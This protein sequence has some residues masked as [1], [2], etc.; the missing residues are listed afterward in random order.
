MLRDAWGMN[1]QPAAFGVGLEGFYGSEVFDD[2]CK[3]FCLQLV[4]WLA[5]H[6]FVR[7]SLKVTATGYRF[8]GRKSLFG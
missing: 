4:Y 3:H 8:C 6:S 1:F 2:A 5:T 7:A